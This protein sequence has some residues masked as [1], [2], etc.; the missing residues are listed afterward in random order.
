MN[1]FN[2][3]DHTEFLS[4]I[5]AQNAALKVKIKQEYDNACGE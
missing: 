3:A 4:N 1:D 5:A 2:L